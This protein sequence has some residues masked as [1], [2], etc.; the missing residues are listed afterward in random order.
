M[1]EGWDGGETGPSRESVGKTPSFPRRRKPRTEKTPSFP[2]RR[3]PRTEKNPSFPRKPESRSQ[4]PQIPAFAGVTGL[5]QPIQAVALPRDL[6]SEDA[7]RIAK[8]LVKCQPFSQPRVKGVTKAFTQLPST[9]APLPGRT[10]SPSSTP[11]V[12]SDHPP[13]WAP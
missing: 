10:A 3:E 4:R 9:A 8:G 11:A 1:E 12:P 6:E 13:R 5:S 2:R 7:N